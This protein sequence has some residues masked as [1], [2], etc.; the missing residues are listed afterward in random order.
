M[1]PSPHIIEATVAKIS[2]S[3]LM[4]IQS[5]QGKILEGLL[6]RSLLNKIAASEED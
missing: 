4:S 5:Y 1:T 2:F 3:K 6:S